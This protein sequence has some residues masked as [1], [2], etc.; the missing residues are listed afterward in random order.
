MSIAD[1]SRVTLNY[2]VIGSYIGMRNLAAALFTVA[3][4]PRAE[5]AARTDDA[6]PLGGYFSCANVG[7]CRNRKPHDGLIHESGPFLT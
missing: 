1:R 4:P 5:G 7:K 3:C 2:K 6:I